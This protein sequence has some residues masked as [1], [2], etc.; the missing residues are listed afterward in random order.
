[1]SANDNKDQQKPVSELFTESSMYDKASETVTSAIS[2]V[3]DTASKAYQ[4]AADSTIGAG[5]TS[6]LAST[7]SK[8]EEVMPSAVEG[9]SA[10]VN[11]I[12]TT[13]SGALPTAVTGAVASAADAASKPE[14]SQHADQAQAQSAKKNPDANAQASASSDDDANA[15][16]QAATHVDLQGPSVPSSA[17]SYSSIAAAPPSADSDVLTKAQLEAQAQ[18]LGSGAGLQPGTETTT[19]THAI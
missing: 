19:I 15:A 5:V 6:A 3:V 11:K 10:V 1:M 2:S 17:P 9:A 18:A 14:S 12:T 4:Y 13:V 16:P 8:A 7:K